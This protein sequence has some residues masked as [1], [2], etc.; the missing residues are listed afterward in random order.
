MNNNEIQSSHDAEADS[1]ADAI[2]AVVIVVAFVATC[3]FWIA[4]Q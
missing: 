1:R 3:I 4:G 2:A